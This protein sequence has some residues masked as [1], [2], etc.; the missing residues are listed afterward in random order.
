M[1]KHCVMMLLLLHSVP[2]NGAG[3]A[4]LRVSMNTVSLVNR[5]LPVAT[6]MPV[7]E[8]KHLHQQTSPPRS[9]TSCPA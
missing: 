2:L 8:H 3:C 7:P 9:D 6:V 5:P 4:F 1:Y